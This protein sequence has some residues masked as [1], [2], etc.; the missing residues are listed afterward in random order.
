MINVVPGVKLKGS[1]RSRKMG[2]WLRHTFSTRDNGAVKPFQKRKAREAEWIR[3]L[4]HVGEGIAG[5]PGS[6]IAFGGSAQI[7]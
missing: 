2:L 7:R 4:L 1:N 5:E 6:L 3:F